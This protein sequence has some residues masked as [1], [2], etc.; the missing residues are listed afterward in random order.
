MNSLGEKQAFYAMTVKA[1]M[2]ASVVGYG[3]F[4][5]AFKVVPECERVL[6]QQWFRAIPVK[7]CRAAGA[8][9]RYSAADGL[10]RLKYREP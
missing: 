8:Q 2:T 1:A 10:N 7:F 3:G 5:D 4:A 6:R 9:K